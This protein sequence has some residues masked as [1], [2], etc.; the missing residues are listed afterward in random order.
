[1]IRI[2]KIVRPVES[3]VGPAA[4]PLTAPQEGDLLRGRGGRH[5]RYKIPEEQPVVG[6]A[7]NKW[8]L[9][10]LKHYPSVSWTMF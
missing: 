4:D 7:M 6:R 1:M 9:R 3:I 10:L 5:W 2:L 8:A